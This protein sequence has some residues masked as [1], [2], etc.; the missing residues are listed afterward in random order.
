MEINY[1]NEQISKLSTFDTLKWIYSNF[2]SDKIKLSTSFGIEGCLLIDMLHQIG[3]KPR[4]FTIDTG[5]NFEETYKVWNE[6]CEKYGFDIEVYYPAEQDLQTF[7]RENGGPNSIFRSKDIR[8]ECCR[9][10]KVEPLKR[11]LENTDVWI[12]ALRR[13]QSES[14]KNQPLVDWS[15][16]YNLVKICPLV[17]WSEANV[18]EYIKNNKVPYNEL[19]DRGYKTI[20]CMP[21]TREVR[22]IDDTRAGR[23]W[24]EED[25]DK[26]CGIHI[27]NG[28]VVRNKKPED[29]NY[30]I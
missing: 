14:R 2:D 4:I 26:E 1:I 27:E 8:K 30:S 28:K 11:A 23:W 3:V 21:C 19:Y 17:E 10:R 13:G 24:W 25:S 18:W 29:Y 5:R 9:I 22:F 7:H 15:N 16:Q 6:T 20:G 12:T